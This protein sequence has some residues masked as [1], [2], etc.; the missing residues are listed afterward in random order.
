MQTG[1]RRAR[2]GLLAIAVAGSVAAAG[3]ATG[4]ERVPGVRGGRRSGAEA[5]ERPVG[6]RFLRRVDDERRDGARFTGRAV[7][8]SRRRGERDRGQLDAEA[9]LD[10]GQAARVAAARARLDAKH[11]ERDRND[12]EQ[13]D[14]ADAQSLG[15]SVP[16]PSTR[17]GA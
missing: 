12:G 2:I 10:R 1:W 8:D 11:R 7:D 15:H 4:G 9:I 3:L 13:P 17:H 14:D 6:H 16:P 5:H